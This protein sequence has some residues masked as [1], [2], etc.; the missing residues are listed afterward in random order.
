MWHQRFR[1]V[2]AE[3]GGHRFPLS[4]VSIP[5]GPP[6]ALIVHG[7][8]EFAIGGGFRPLIIE[9]EDMGDSLGVCDPQ[10]VF[11]FK[12]SPVKTPIWGERMIGFLRIT[13]PKGPLPAYGATVCGQITALELACF[14]ALESR[15]IPCNIPRS[16]GSVESTTTGRELGRRTYHEGMKD[17]PALGH[18]RAKSWCISDMLRTWQRH[19][20]PRRPTGSNPYR[21][22]I[23]WYGRRSR[24]TSRRVSQIH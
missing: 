11:L 20:H 8:G 16:R 10:A 4:S 5:L 2:G 22:R 13:Y 21:T 3:S 17:F 1:F 7:G 23:E 14:S 24:V 6:N 18:R 19:P 12:V 15:Q 9:V